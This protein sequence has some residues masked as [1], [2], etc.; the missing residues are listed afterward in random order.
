MSDPEKQ[1]VSAVENT[2]D[3]QKLK[4][5]NN[6]PF[7]IQTYAEK[8]KDGPIWLHIRNTIDPKWEIWKIAWNK[9]DKILEW[10]ESSEKSPEKVKARA[11]ILKVMDSRIEETLPEWQDIDS[12]AKIL[13]KPDWTKFETEKKAKEF[14]RE[15]FL[16]WEIKSLDIK[17]T[18]N[19]T[20]K[21]E[22]ILKNNKKLAD[23]NTEKNPE[24]AKELI[25]VYW[26]DEIEWYEWLIKSAWKRWK[27]L[28]TNLEEFDAFINEQWEYIV[29]QNNS[30][31]KDIGKDIENYNKIIK[32]N[33]DNEKARWILAF[34]EKLFNKDWDFNTF[35]NWNLWK[36]P[37][38]L[39]KMSPSIKKVLEVWM[40]QIWVN[41]R[42]G[43]ADKYLQEIWHKWRKS[44]WNENAWCAAFVN[45]T[46][47]KSWMDYNSSLASQSFINWSWK[48]HV[49]FK[50]WNQL[51]WWNQSDMV[52]LKPLNLDKVEWWVMPDNRWE[53]HRRWESTFNQ[54][55]IPDWAIL[56]FSSSKNTR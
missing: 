4:E 24:F 50:I 29:S 28:P 39:D 9:I 20:T 10:E 53:I 49:W 31:K 47:K 12:I 37:E 34:L 44:A 16:S 38:W 55:K 48:W 19:W 33:P 11:D 22:N 30:D 1:V 2:T 15:Q 46:L 18:D 13:K 26:I 32:A 45:W 7:K 27:K 41:E 25:W 42:D 8:V 35:Y 36:L 14:L 51:L 3:T 21:Y 23:L 43:S 40:S 5:G 56:V 54:N 17:N 52:S 6:T